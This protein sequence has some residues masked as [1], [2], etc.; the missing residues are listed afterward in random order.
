MLLSY[1]ALSD[2]DSGSLVLLE[3][4]RCILTPMLI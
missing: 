4:A 3:V 2:Y 1:D